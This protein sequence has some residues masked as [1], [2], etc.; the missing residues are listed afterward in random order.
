MN[1]ESGG[2]RRC[3]G[4]DGEDMIIKVPEGKCAKQIGTFKYSTKAG[5]DKTVPIVSILNK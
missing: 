5:F 3:H 4:S 2:K 1:G